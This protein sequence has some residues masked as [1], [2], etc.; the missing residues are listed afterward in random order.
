MK[1]DGSLR[2]VKKG[3]K[4]PSL[5][6]Q[7]LAAMA[8]RTLVYGQGG[9]GGT[10]NLSSFLLQNQRVGCS[11]SSQPHHDS[12]FISSSSPSFLGKKLLQILSLNWR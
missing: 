6:S 3:I 7:E 10:S 12:L 1:G 11:S 9:A 2:R 4:I 5:D 8:G